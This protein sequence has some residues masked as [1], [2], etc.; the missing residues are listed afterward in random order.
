MELESS[1]QND[2]ININ[3]LTKE[4]V[5]YKILS[6]DG[7]GIKGLIPL[8]YLDMLE[9]I[10]GKKI[11][12]LF[13]FFS[14]ASVGGI[15]AI[16]LSQKKISAS[17]LLVK[18]QG[19]LKNKIFPSKRYFDYLF[20]QKPLYD[21]DIAE[22]VANELIGEFLYSEAKGNFLITSSEQD[23]QENRTHR[24]FGAGHFVRGGTCRG[25]PRRADGS[26]L[27]A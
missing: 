14:G 17:E 22:E 19:Q 1:G 6:I 13:D 5:K 8:Y 24:G 23:D 3:D 16:I 12:E 11:W 7:G 26:G 15:I 9:K 27:R 20:C 2:V 4:K 21:P 10:S 25:R 18:F